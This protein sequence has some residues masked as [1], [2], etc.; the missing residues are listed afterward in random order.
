MC[1]KAVLSWLPCS[2]E[3]TGF[4]GAR[5]RNLEKKLFRTLRVSEVGYLTINHDRKECWELQGQV[6]ALF[7]YGMW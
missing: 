2:F 4:S 5:N 7:E 6:R 3:V 1:V